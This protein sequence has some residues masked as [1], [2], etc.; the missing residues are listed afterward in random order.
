MTFS[1]RVLTS[2][3]VPFNSGC[4]CLKGEFEIE[5]RWLAHDTQ[6]HEAVGHLLAGIALE[7][8]NVGLTVEQHEP[9]VIREEG[10]E[11]ELGHS[12]GDHGVLL[13]VRLAR[14]IAHEKG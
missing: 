9:E 13:I 1:A 12:T 11:L 14:M 7:K 4:I 10:F 5:Q 6:K 2:H 8:L 3:L